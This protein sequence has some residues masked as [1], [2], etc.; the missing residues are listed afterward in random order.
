[1]LEAMILAVLVLGGA[2]MSAYDFDIPQREDDRPDTEP[3]ENSDRLQLGDSAD[4]IDAGRGNDQVSAG[5]G[6]DTVTGGPGLD[7]LQGEA[8]HDQLAGGEFH[9]I[10]LGG[11]GNDLLEG[12]GGKDILFGGDGDDTVLGGDWDDV[13][14]GDAGSD[15]LLGGRGNDNIFGVTVVPEPDAGSL[16]SLRDGDDPAGNIFSLEADDEADTLEGGD[17]HDY[18]A[19]G[20]GDTANGGTGRD[21]F[22]LLL[23]PEATG[24]IT[25]EDYQA[26]TD[27]VRISGKSSGAFNVQLEEESGDALILDG[28]VL[29][30]RLTGAGSSFSLDQL[31]F[32]PVN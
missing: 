11:S 8:G 23:T 24:A 5:G 9:D 27:S 30:A 13:I 15:I 29:V 31:E 10:L 14:S 4:S 20:A 17:G 1:M 12:E 7:I 2:S 18:L 21:V 6:D 26:G 16:K 3:T 19:L 22:D 25:I 28:G 32:A